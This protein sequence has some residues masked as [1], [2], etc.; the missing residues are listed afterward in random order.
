M[1][2]LPMSAFPGQTASNLSPSAT[3]QPATGSFSIILGYSD[4]QTDRQTNKQTISATPRPTSNRRLTSSQPVLHS[5]TPPSTSQRPADPIS[6]SQPPPT[7][8]LLPSP[9]TNDPR[10]PQTSPD[11]RIAVSRQTNSPLP[12]CKPTTFES[13]IP[14]SQKEQF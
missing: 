11:D 7:Q 12:S 8:Q 5:T 14:E 13:R 4:R 3:S 2:D 10:L 9:Q 6:T 1:K